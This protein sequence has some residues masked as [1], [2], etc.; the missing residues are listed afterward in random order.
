MFEKLTS[1]PICDHKEYD[2]FMIC[3]DHMLTGESFAISQ[4]KNCSFLFTN[5]RPILSEIGKYYH[6]DEYISH[7]NQL[8]NIRDLLYKLARFY[9]LRNKVKLINSLSKKNNV[10]DFGCGTGDFLYSCRQSSWNIYGYEPEEKARK[11]AEI[12][13]KA[14][15]NKTLLEL[16]NLPQFE[17]ITLWHVLEHIHDLND[18]LSL[19][20][21]KLAKNGK[22]LLAVPNAAS[23][24]AKIYNEYWAAYDVPRHLYHFTQK[25]MRTLLHKHALKIYQ[26][27]PMTLDAYYVSMLSEKYKNGSQNLIKSFTNGYKSNDYGKKNKLNYSSI[28]YIAGK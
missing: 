26:T 2:N 17:I 5:P 25:T 16:K 1:C 22:L 18:T 6:S 27:L 28:I 23:L 9:T 4:C 7:S 10:M 8:N 14:S 15:I 24:D 12:K 21:G 20:K 13:T 11:Q 3:K 19:L